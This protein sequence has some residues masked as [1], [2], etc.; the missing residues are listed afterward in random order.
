MAAERT[1]P[2][3]FH[4]L[5]DSGVRAQRG[6]GPPGLLAVND[7]GSFPEQAG[8]LTL[9]Y[10]D[11]T[12][13]PNR[14]VVA[15]PAGRTR[16]GCGAA[17]SPEE[18]ARQFLAERGDLW[19][20]SAADAAGI[21]VTGVSGTGL[22]TVQLLQRVNGTEVFNSD[23]TAAVGP[24]NQLVAVAGQ[25]FPGAADA[26]AARGF[27]AG[28][29]TSTEE[30]IARAAADLTGLAYLPAEFVLDDAAADGEY[31]FYDFRPAA[32]EADR[33]GMQRQVRV[34]DVLF[35][36]GGEQFAAAY[37]LELWVKGWPAFSY[38]VDAVEEPDVLFRRNLAADFGSTGSTTPA[39]R[40]CVR[41]TARRLALRTR[42]A[43]PMGFRRRSS[44][45]N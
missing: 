21:E 9:S 5:Y 15:A 14:V 13:L 6:A 27:A 30:A 23:V 37:Y 42:R 18:A 44:K 2:A 29:A 32:T 35:P 22:R 17:A 31:R 3:D 26:P 1:L 20:L 8:D 25:F 12:G 11:A 39:T 28:P 19:R 24:A 38:V 4:A 40:C 41:R 10:D 36:L 7:A 43:S 16:R 34:K 45:P 33:P